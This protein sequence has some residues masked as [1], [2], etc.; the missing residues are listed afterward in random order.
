[1]NLDHYLILLTLNTTLIKHISV[2]INTVRF[3]EENVRGDLDELVLGRVLTCSTQDTIY[4]I[5]SY[6]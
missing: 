3:V 5:L 1:M 2:R 4:T 6:E